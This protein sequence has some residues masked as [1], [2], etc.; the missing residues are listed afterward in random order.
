MNSILNKLNISSGIIH[1]SIKILTY[2]EKEININEINKISVIFNSNIKYSIFF[3]ENCH[4]IK[5]ISSD[6]YFIIKEINSNDYKFK[7]RE[8][9]FEYLVNYSPFW[10]RRIKWGLSSFIKD[11][12]LNETHCFNEAGLLDYS[13]IENIL[14]W[15]KLPF[16][17]NNNLNL[18]TI[19][20]IGEQLSIKYENERTKIEPTQISLLGGFHGYDIL[21]KK[22]DNDYNNIYIECKT[23]IN[24]KKVLIS[25]TKNEWESAIKNKNDYYFHIWI[26][27]TKLRFSKLYI[28]STYEMEFHIPN[29]SDSNYG[30]FSIA[31][32]DLTN[33]ILKKEPSVIYENLSL[34]EYLLQE[35]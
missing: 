17:E 10:T 1:T 6:R 19:G 2:F 18:R 14:W 33:Y 4:Y 34:F 9:L 35:Y 23:T 27:N 30:V 8:L 21:S 31:E 16:F 15:N 22:T 25:I 11:L 5:K 28:L 7:V 32:I 13:V 12:T 3:L 29:P 26:I 20:I 24:F